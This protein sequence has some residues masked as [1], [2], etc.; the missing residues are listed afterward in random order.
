MLGDRVAEAVIGAYGRLPKHGKP[1]RAGQEWTVLS[2]IVLQ[3]AGDEVGS[4]S[5]EAAACLG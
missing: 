3:L 1:T 2:G 4:K 5:D